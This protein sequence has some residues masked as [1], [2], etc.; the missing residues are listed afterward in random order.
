MR[1]I[2]KLELIDDFLNEGIVCLDDILKLGKDDLKDMKINIA[3]RNRIL[4]LIDEIKNKK[5]KL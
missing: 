5:V 1:K 2:E 4:Y 3:G